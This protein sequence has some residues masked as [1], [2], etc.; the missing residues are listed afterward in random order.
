MGI[1]KALIADFTASKSKKVSIHM[2]E[3][4]GETVTA[5]Q[6]VEAQ[7]L[8]EAAKIAI[9]CR[10]LVVALPRGQE[11][12][13][14][15]YKIYCDLKEERSSLH[16]SAWLA[17]RLILAD[18]VVARAGADGLPSMPGVA[19]IQ[20]YIEGF[21]RRHGVPVWKAQYYELRFFEEHHDERSAVE[22]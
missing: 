1:F 21:F 8:S 5:I 3:L 11:G 19:L 12:Y 15:A 17:S 16:A 10:E 14:R 2:D 6:D 22:G 18:H 9:A 7:F 13:D 20:G 4:V